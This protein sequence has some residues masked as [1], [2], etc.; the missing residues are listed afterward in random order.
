MHAQIQKWNYLELCHRLT[1]HSHAIIFANNVL[2]WHKLQAY[3][4]IFDMSTTTTQYQQ[5][6]QSA[7]ICWK[8]L[9]SYQMKWK[10]SFAREKTL[11]SNNNNNAL[12]TSEKF[13]ETDWFLCL[14]III[15]ILILYCDFVLCVHLFCCFIAFVDTLEIRMHDWNLGLHYIV[16]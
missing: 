6:S 4:V 15:V 13:D 7:T 3:T 9:T 2:I 14:P 11:V 16:L 10:S 12:P 1:P 5:A 8:H